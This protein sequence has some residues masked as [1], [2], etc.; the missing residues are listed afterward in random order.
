MKLSFAYLI[1]LLTLF[2]C[3]L[4]DILSRSD[5]DL[6]NH[7]RSLS[8]NPDQSYVISKF[9]IKPDVSFCLIRT[10]LH[11]IHSLQNFRNKSVKLEYLGE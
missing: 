8:R 3:R 6:K 9:R 10:F 1:I 4:K 7:F 2:L 11:G 5:F